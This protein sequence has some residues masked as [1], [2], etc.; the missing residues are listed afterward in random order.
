MVRNT[1]DAEDLT[2]EVFLQVF[3]KMD[4][5]RGQSAFFTWL[6]RVA[7]NV[8]LMKLRGNKARV[9]VPLP[10]DVEPDEESGQY[11]QEMSA[12]D[13]ALASLIDRLN[14]ERAADCL[15]PGCRRILLLHNVAGYEH[16]EIAELLGT[17]MG[18]SKSQLH[19]ARYRMRMLLRESNPT[20]VHKLSPRSL[21]RKTTKVS[22]GRAAAD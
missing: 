8:V 4:S 18:N 10:Q 13:L 22:I 9:E 21:F 19:R 2:Q 1:A 20:R 3:R 5:F 14:L 12:P 11:P 16:H 6:Q 7:I 15:P 17:S